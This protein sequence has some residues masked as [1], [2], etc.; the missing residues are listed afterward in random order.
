MTSLTRDVASWVVVM[1]VQVLERVARVRA[2][3]G[4]SAAVVRRCYVGTGL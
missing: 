3:G 1:D 2:R 4:V